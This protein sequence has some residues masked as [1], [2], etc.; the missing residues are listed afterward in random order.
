[1]PKN[2]RESFIFTIM[3]CFF[4]VFVM[5]IYNVSLHMG[6]ISLK[7]LQLAWL[8]FPIAFL[9]A[10]CADWF[11][12][13]NFAKSIAFRFFLNEK[14]SIMKK[15]IVISCC[16]VVPMVLIMSCYGTLEQCIQFGNW[17][18]AF[19]LWIQNIGKNIIVALPLQLLVAGPMIRGLFRK[20]FPE[21]TI[22]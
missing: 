3:M 20:M 4:M 8:G 15:A 11:L 14:S 21:G 12:V 10:M 9:C 18:R 16:M 19:I 17:N 6:E 1:M 5:S 22:L 2:K 7:T 13:G